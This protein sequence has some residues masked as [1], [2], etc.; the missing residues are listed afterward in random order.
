MRPDLLALA[1]SALALAL[2]C[3][4]GLS[5]QVVTEPVDDWS[6]VAEAEDV[7]FATE[8]GDTFTFV[9]AGPLVHEGALYL[10]AS[11]IFARDDGALDAL[12]AGEGL[13]MRVGSKLYDLDA[14]R[15][16]TPEEVSPLVPVILRQSRI[17]ATGARWDPE[18]ERYPGTQARQWFFRLESAAPVTR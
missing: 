14:R 12:L 5:G 8:S 3:S 15:L 18:P 9:A 13:R 2:G 16:T 4:R 7:A 1:L 17:E 11:T 10:Q 6:F